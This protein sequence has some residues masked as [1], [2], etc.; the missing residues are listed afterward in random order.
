MNLRVVSNRKARAIKHNANVKKLRK[1]TFDVRG[2]NFI[3]ARQQI[4]YLMDK[5]ELD[6]LALLETHVN[7]IG[8]QSIGKYTFYFSSDIEDDAR[9]KTDAE[10]SAYNAEVK[11]EKIPFADAQR[12]SV[13]IRQQSAEK[14]GCAFVLK[15]QPSLVLTYGPSTIKTFP[16]RLVRN[17]FTVY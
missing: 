11:L 14:L 12:E 9:V 17:P 1:A 16:F 6:L 2:M 13:R 10:L 5:H 3:T 8:K 7:Y 4:V 15:R